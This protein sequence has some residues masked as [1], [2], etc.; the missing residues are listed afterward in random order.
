MPEN[1]FS[2]GFGSCGRDSVYIEANRILDSC[3]DRDCFENVRVFLTDFGCEIIE[4]T[5]TVRAKSACIAWTYVGLDP[6]PFNKGFYSVTIR[7]Y[8][9]MNFEACVAGGRAQEFDGVAVLEKKI[10]LFGGEGSINTFRSNSDNSGFCSEPMPCCKEKTLPVATLEVAEPI[11]LDTRIVENV[12]DCCC[13][14]CAC[15]VPDCVVEGISGALNNDFGKGRERYLAVSLGI[16]S[17]VRITR[18]AQLMI[19]GASEYCVPD[20]ECVEAQKDD[21][22]GIFRSMSFPISEFCGGTFPVTG[23]DKHCFEK[24]FDKPGKCGCGN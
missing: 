16:F 8:V 18:P 22:C 1:K 23:G 6:V 13:C 17:I 9:K 11:I 10:I 24:P 2:G 19:S 7:F 21:P 15:D 5:N 14:C 4:H 12:N 20:K 3:R